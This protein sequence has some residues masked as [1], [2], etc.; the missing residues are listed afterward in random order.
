MA[1]KLFDLARSCQERKRRGAGSAK[2]A[3]GDGEEKESEKDW[4]VREKPDVKFDDIAGL[5]E[6]KEEIRLKMIYPVQ[7][8]DLAARFGIK[9]GGGI[10]L[11]GPPGT[12]KTMI[13]KAVATE[14]DAVFFSIKPSQVMSKWVGE[15]EQNIEELFKTAR[16]EPLSVVFLDEIEA[17]VPARREAASG[18][19]QR[20]VP[21][22]LAELEG[23]DTASKNPIL[24]LGAT[25]EPWSLDP[26][27][28]RPGRFDEKVYIGLPDL[29]ARRRMLDIYL[30]GRPVDASLDLDALAAR[31][32]GY[33]GADIRQVC[34]KAA[35]EAFLESIEKGVDAG[36]GEGLLE[37]VLRAVRPSVKP[38]DLA[39]FE[40]Y[41][42]VT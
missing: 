30:K 1:R 2:T 35:G 39:R 32:E 28:L 24:F 5:D 27:V 15:A 37:R 40:K 3:A 19:M 29:P 8:P 12:G 4:V 25:N 18:V 11:Y 26:A 10:L 31:L 9:S 42:E 13:A 16:A 21:Q 38:G 6:V 36:L 14:I 34:D 23:F 33:S 17:L 22:I 41:A 20:V 7:R